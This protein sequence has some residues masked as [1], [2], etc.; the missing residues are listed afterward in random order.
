MNALSANEVRLRLV[1]ISDFDDDALERYTLTFSDDELARVVQLRTEQ[2]RTEFVVA[3]GFLREMLGRYLE[4]DP[5]SVVF[6]GERHEKPSVLSPAGTG[7]NFSLSHSGGKILYAFA[8]G[9]KVG[10]D[11]EKIEP[12]K[13]DATVAHTIFTHQELGEWWSLPEQLRARGFFCGW[14]R[15]EAFVKAVGRGMSLDLKSF[16]VTLDPRKPASLKLPPEFGEQQW[17]L[18]A[19]KAGPEFA[20]AVAVEGSGYELVS[21][22]ASRL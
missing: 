22:Q 19:L 8:T 12:E 3:H 9:R 14:V 20:A 2:L 5:V 16:S 4:V 17:N 10:V 1:S 7:I 15:K 11:I 21:G 13:C 18:H 6:W